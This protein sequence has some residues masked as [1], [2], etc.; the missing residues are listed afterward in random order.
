MMC[1][2]YLTRVSTELNDAQTLSA[3]DIHAQRDRS[4]SPCNARKDSAECNV[5]P[6]VAEPLPGSPLPC[7]RVAGF[8]GGFV[9]W[10]TSA[11]VIS[12]YLRPST[13][14]SAW[15]VDRVKEIFR[16]SSGGASA[17]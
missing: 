10:G 5:D 4:C 17:P 13:L 12:R 6:S 14:A 2:E 8:A 9:R 16:A 3:A 7:Y 11:G 1:W 15:F